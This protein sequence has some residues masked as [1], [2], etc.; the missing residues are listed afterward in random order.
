RS[1]TANIRA[2][3][4]YDRPD[5]LVVGELRG[6]EVPSWFEAAGSG[7]PV[8]T[9]AHS[10]ELGDALKRLNTL[11]QAAGL[12]ASVL[13]AVRVWVVCGKVVS[14]EGGVQRGVQAVYVVE[15]GGF[16]P[17]YKAG[18]YLPEESFLKLLPPELQLS[19]EGASDAER[20][21][22]AIKQRLNARVDGM[23]FE[24]MEPIIPEDVPEEVG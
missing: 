17:V 6:E 11:I 2:T 8:L 9:T 22:G 10:R 19:L 3:R 18:R 4:R 1:V 23:R 7:I 20:V 21:Y 5:L 24:R 12:R 15:A 16:V 14:S 13:D